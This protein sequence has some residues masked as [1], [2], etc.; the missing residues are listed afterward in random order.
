MGAVAGRGGPGDAVPVATGSEA[1]VCPDCGRHFARR[2]QGHD[3]A[4]ALSIDEYFATGPAFERPIFEAVMA[5][6]SGAGVDP[7]HVEPVSVGI[8]LKRPQRFAQLRTMTR[9]VAV[10]FS[11]PRALRSP[12]IARKVIPHGGRY[13]HVVNVRDARE[14]DDELVA[15]LVEAHATAGGPGDR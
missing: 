5:G 9:W 2:R 4:P 8:F 10:G 1:W 11:L 14:V 3:C 15:W 7:V 6:L 12:R 13:H